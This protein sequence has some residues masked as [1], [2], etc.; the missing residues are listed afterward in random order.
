MCKSSTYLNPHMRFLVN[1][2]CYHKMCES[3]VDRIFSHG[4]APCPVAGCKRTL[5]KGRFRPLTF[6]DIQVE[7]EVDIRRRVS[8]IFN[9]REDDFE[10]LH[11]YNNYLNDV[12]D[13]TFNL[14]NG[15]DLADTE[16][17]IDAYTASN[18]DQIA[19]NEQLSAAD[20]Q[21]FHARQALEQERA[22][23]R[24]QAALR[25]D[26]DE[27]R[28]RLEG[29]QD[30]INKLAT[31]SGDAR[32]IASDGRRSALTRVQARKAQSVTPDAAPGD[33]DGYSFG[34]LKKRTAPEPEK[35]YDPFGGYSF[36]PRFYLVQDDYSWDW[37][38]MAKRDPLIT[39]GGYDLK[40]YY[41]RALCDAFSG[42]GVFVGDEAGG[43]E[44]VRDAA[45]A[46]EGAAA[47]AAAS[48]TT[49]RGQD[50]RMADDVF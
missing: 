36:E 3:C 19:E 17:R 38:T 12:E 34:G 45:V 8:R 47:A 16:R 7:R 13:L 20:R 2:E 5:R 9:R 26:D 11:D 50:V 31:S 46:T 23:Q 37:F 44:P 29:R 24:R 27:R 22:K 18:R 10:S 35:P 42:L 4:P 48:A 49:R 33:A 39:V 40:E 14:V 28:E 41:S 25:Q 21:T 30:I 32:R 43:A 6:E 15:I 1:P